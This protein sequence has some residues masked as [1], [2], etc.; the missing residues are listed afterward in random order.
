MQYRP[1]LC[2]FV[3]LVSTPIL[4]Q[5]FSPIVVKTG[6]PTP[7]VVRTGEPFRIT[8]RAQF[9]DEV[10]ILDEQMQPENIKADPFEVI[11]LEVVVLPDQGN[12]DSGIVHVK[13]FIYTFRIIK[14]EK[15]DKK[16]P[17]F[18]FI[19]VIKKAGTTEVNA[20]ESSEPKEI[21]TDEVGVR[22]VYS[23]VKP[24]PL[25]IRD[26]IVFQLF[27]WSGG[28]LRNAGYAI[29][30][31]S[32][33]SLLIVLIAWVYFGKS[34]DKKASENKSSEITAEV[35][36]EIVPD[37]LPKKARRKFLRELKK[38]LEAKGTDVSSVELEKKVFSLLR[39]LVLV[40]LSGTPVKPLT[41]DTP[42]E[43]FKR[44][45]GLREK[46]KEAMGLKY[47]A[48]ASL[49]EKLKNYYEDMESGRLV[50][51]TEPRLE[52]QAL[53]NI[54]EGAGFWIKFREAFLNSLRISHA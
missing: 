12:A 42:A 44:L 41:S 43:L 46:Q 53:L 20:K 13:D 40:E 32:S 14:P 7:S 31:A 19:W 35:V 23:P 3:L 47:K 10:L 54:V 49:A 29:I 37:I 26:E 50:H 51:F 52:I 9:Y 39:E 24:P 4:A 11:K 45:L 34:K 2:A 21:P 15:G 16:L 1:L 5:E 17:S 8:Y 6:Q 48:F 28:T 36:V 33:M 30:A 22:Y 18:N 25:N 27:R 38:L